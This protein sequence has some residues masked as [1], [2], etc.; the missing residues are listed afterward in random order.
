MT[1]RDVLLLWF[2]L[3]CF[4]TAALMYSALRFPGPDP[5]DWDDTPTW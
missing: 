2:G 3:C 5:M 4:A 1:A